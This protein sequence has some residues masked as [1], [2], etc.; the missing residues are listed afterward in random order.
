MSLRGM[1]KYGPRVHMYLEAGERLLDVQSGIAFRSPPPQVTPSGSGPIIG[2]GA[3]AGRLLSGMPPRVSG[4]VCVT[5]R[6][7]FFC[8]T[9]FVKVKRMW[10]QLPRT[11]VVAVVSG[12]PLLFALQ[13][14]DGSQAWF[15]GNQHHRASIANALGQRDIGTL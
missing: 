9:G 15:T 5:D 8:G 6:R 14:A 13:F 7:V 1:R 3:M 2:T 11:D 4:I 12:T 10:W